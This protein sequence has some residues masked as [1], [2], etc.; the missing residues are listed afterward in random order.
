MNKPNR[1][2]SGQWVHKSYHWT[3]N[4][5]PILHIQSRVEQTPARPKYPPT[6]HTKLDPTNKQNQSLPS[7]FPPKISYSLQGR[8]IKRKGNFQPSKLKTRSISNKFRPINSRPSQHQ[9]INQSRNLSHLY[10]PF[11]TITT[12]HVGPKHFILQCRHPWDRTG[13]LCNGRN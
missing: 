10:Y 2:W 11:R 5:R 8:N 3:T 9:P 4:N 13:P 6:V 7:I 1:N 12:L